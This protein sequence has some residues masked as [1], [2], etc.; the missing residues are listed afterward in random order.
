MN[1]D[2]FLTKWPLPLGFFAEYF[3][4]IWNVTKFLRICRSFG[5]PRFGVVLLSVL[6]ALVFWGTLFCARGGFELG[7]ERFFGSW[8][9]FAGGFLPFPAMKTVALLL[10]FNV[11]CACLFRIPHTRKHWGVLFMHV[12]VLVLIAGSFAAEKQ[13]ESFAAFGLVGTSVVLDSAQNVSF[14]I[15]SADSSGCILLSPST[16]DSLLV[17]LNSPQKIG[18]YSLYFGE[19]FSI[20]PDRE[21]VRLGVKRDPFSFVPYLFSALLLLGILGH[22]AAKR[23]KR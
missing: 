1:E 8:I 6:F 9:L 14:R 22:L 18:G 12:A 2:F 10:F 4:Y 11:L 19:K 3:V 15:V 20:P 5:S 13:R 21:I 23:K 17:S 7:V 16:E